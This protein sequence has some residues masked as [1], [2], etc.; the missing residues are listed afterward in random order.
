MFKK[1]VMFAASLAS[2][3]FK[4]NKIDEKTKQLRALSCFGDGTIKKCPFLRESKINGYFYCGKCGCGDNKNTWLMK[5]SEQYSKLDYP[6]LNC[7]VKMPG[8]TNYDPNYYEIQSGDRKRLIE[9]YD[10]E[11]LQFIQVT[12]GRDPEKEKLME[13][14]NKIIGN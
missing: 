14:V 4:N 10:P 11:K 2:R 8:F 7:P 13:S 6:V 1:M 5:E 3:G 12:I 9:D